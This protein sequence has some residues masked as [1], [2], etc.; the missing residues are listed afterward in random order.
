MAERQCSACGDIQ[1]YLR[2]ETGFRCRACRR[3]P[4]QTCRCCGAGFNGRKRQ[5]CSEKCQRLANSRK[6]YKPKAREWPLSAMYHKWKNAQRSGYSGTLEDYTEYRERRG[7]GCTN[8]TAWIKWMP[9]KVNTPRVPPDPRPRMSQEDQRRSW[10]RYQRLR[11]ERDLDKCLARRL[12]QRAVERGSLYKPDH[13]NRCKILTPKH[14]LHGHHADGYEGPAK[15][16]VTWL[17][18]GCHVIEEGAWGG[19]LKCQGTS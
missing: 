13:C 18:V 1:K 9:E 10:R 11:R 16:V 7:L 2:P 6:N 3:P 14:L 5:F 17:C 15:T 4:S 12:I 19:A 8:K